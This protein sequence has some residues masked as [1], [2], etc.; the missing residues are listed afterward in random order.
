MFVNEVISGGTTPVLEAMVGFA[1]QRQRI[2]SHNIANWETPNFRPIDVSPAEFRQALRDA[3][4][5]RRAGGNMGELSF[6]A[7]DTVARNPD[8][9]LELT[10]RLMDGPRAGILQHDRNSTDLERM[11]QDVVENLGA[12]RAASD[13]LRSRTTLMNSAIS[14]RV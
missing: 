12:F 14:E 11:M 7:N 5:R 4:D 1:G 2:L 13:L 8:G 9:S 10:A 6:R 3:V